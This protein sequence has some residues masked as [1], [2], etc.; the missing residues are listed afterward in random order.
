MTRLLCP[1]HRSAAL[2]A[3]LLCL[4]A[5][6]ADAQQSSAS[7]AVDPLADLAWLAGCWEGTLATGAIYEEMWLAP[8]D[9]TLL[10]LARMTRGGR[11]VSFEFMRIIDDAGTPVFI[12]QP[13]GREGTPFRATA[14]TAGEAVFENPGHDFPQRVIYRH[15]PP[16]SLRARIEGDADGQVRGMD[17]PLRRLACPGPPAAADRSGREP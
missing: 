16:D 12:A 14:A 6:P 8:R 9:G 10:G 5:P 3:A 2:A 17:F 1:L 7:P 4:T 11:T 13:S 15:T